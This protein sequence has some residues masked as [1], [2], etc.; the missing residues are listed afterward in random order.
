MPAV[1]FPAKLL[2]TYWD[3]KKPTLIKARKT[4]IG[5]ALDSLK[6]LADKIKWEDFDSM[7][8]IKNADMHLA[9]WP[10][11]FASKV[12]PVADEAAEVEKLLKKWSAT[13][14]KEKLTPKSAHELCDEIAG[15]AKDYYAQLLDYEGTQ[16]L[17][18]LKQ[19]KKA[20]EIVGKRIKPALTKAV[21]KLDGLIKDIVT[22]AKSP[23]SETFHGLFAKDSNAR[24][25]TTACK[26]WDQDMIEFPE[27]RNE[28][29]DGKAMV[30]YYPC[31]ED[32]GAEWDKNKFEEKVN[33]KYK[34]TG[35]AVWRVHAVHLVKSVPTVK[36]FQTI[37]K[38][39]IKKVED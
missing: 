24:G 4:G 13:F 26:Y 32:Y 7:G 33:S 17:E 18:L 37:L 25:Y 28:C 12:K 11:K 9:A 20:V 15:E 10:A 23:T 2:R 8:T 36:E 29:F 38:K 34:E 27:I 5:D 16:A 3:K 30:T 39:A 6:N 22:F 19:R 31:M 1:D 14:K 35:E 21:D